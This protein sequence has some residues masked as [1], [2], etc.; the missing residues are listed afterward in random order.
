MASYT[1]KR[2]YE[3]KYV[4]L[5]EDG[6]RVASAGRFMPGPMVSMTGPRIMPPQMAKAVARA[7]Q[8]LA[9]DLIREEA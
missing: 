7:Q 1:V 8:R 4:V 5:D 2:E 6:D 3:G 9:N